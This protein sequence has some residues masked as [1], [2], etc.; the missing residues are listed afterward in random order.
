[1]SITQHHLILAL[2]MSVQMQSTHL[3]GHVLIL[4]DA[5]LPACSLG[6]PLPC[7][8]VPYHDGGRTDSHCLER[9]Q[10]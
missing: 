7:H 10:C 9:Q 2:S 5:Q 1:M 4:N 8:Q 6:N 3:P